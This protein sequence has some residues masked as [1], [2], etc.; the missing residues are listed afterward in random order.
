MGCPQGL[1]QRPLHEVIVAHQI[2]HHSAG[3]HPHLRR[4][5]SHDPMFMHLFIQGKKE[6][7]RPSGH[8]SVVS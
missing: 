4:I 3:D 8:E 7:K 6:N 5:P 2:N 1:E